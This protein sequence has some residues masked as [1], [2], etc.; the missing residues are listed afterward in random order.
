M[1]G[2]CLSAGTKNLCP[3]CPTVISGL[4]E[5]ILG[6][7]RAIS[8]FCVLLYENFDF[9]TVWLKP[10]EKEKIKLKRRLQKSEL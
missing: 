5:K 9:I 2:A 7:E 10:T 3:V 6:E 1:E 8:C 4:T